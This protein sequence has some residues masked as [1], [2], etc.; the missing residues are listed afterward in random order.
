MEDARVV[1]ILQEDQPVESLAEGQAGDVL[2][3]RTP[4]YAESGGQIGDQGYL[5]GS[6]GTARVLDTRTPVG[7]VSLHQVKVLKGALRTGDVLRAEVDERRRFAIACNHTATH[8]LHASLRD[9]LGE[10]VKQAGSL[11]APDR[12]RFD[13]THFAAVNPR[14]LEIIEEMVNEQIWNNRPV[15]T[16]LLPIDEA[17][18][19]GAMALFG[20]KYQDVVRV[21]SVEGFSKELC[22][23]THLRQTGQ[24]GAFKIVSESS[25]A[26]GVR[27]V[28]AVTGPEALSPLRP[29]R[30]DPRPGP[31]GAPTWKRTS[32]P[33]SSTGSR[34]PSAACRRKSS[35]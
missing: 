30:E 3:D 5:R 9:V 7:G 14:E 20:E 21:V 18:A 23:G 31:P 29:G 27:R 19:T 4:F 13:F 2:L 26:S 28:E 8:L 10:H 6:A 15:R 34:T 33:S 17:V 25:I 22:G 1:A 12:F 16:D 24:M 35:G 11:V 32:C